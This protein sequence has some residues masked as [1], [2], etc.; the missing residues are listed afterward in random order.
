MAQDQVLGDL[1]EEAIVFIVTT[2]LIIIFGLLKMWSYSVGQD[3]LEFM[4]FLI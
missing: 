2:F 4:I 1:E 3:N